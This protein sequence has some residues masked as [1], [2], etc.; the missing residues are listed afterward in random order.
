MRSILCLGVLAFCGCDAL[1]S[2]R[3]TDCHGTSGGC[4]ADMGVPASTDLAG[5]DLAGV[6]LA[7]ADLAATNPDLSNIPP[8]YLSL[9]NRYYYNGFTSVLLGSSDNKLAIFSTN[10][11]T[12]SGSYNVTNML[13]T[14][15][16]GVSNVIQ[17]S[18]FGSY[19]NAFL[20]MTADGRLMT[21]P[22][23]GMT[24]AF[25]AIYN[26]APHNLN[27][28]WTSNPD[29]S[30]G[31]SLGWAVGQGGTV[32]AVN[33]TNGTAESFTTLA[34]KPPTPHGNVPKT[35]IGYVRVGSQEQ[36]TEGVSL[37]A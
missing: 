4:T 13:S 9:G 7:G 11:N 27:A 2:W 23:T 12:V 20:A 33:Y 15:I 10:G 6:D 19:E 5:A 37:D 22:D 28:L 30:M 32:V 1:W 14:P 35:K 21:R 26:A 24:V 3:L 17:Q 18:A 29:G 16:L 25:S 36:A 8:G 34:M 31:S